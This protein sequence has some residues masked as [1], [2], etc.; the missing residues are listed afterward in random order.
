MFI[1]DMENLWFFLKLTEPKITI[2]QNTSTGR[3]KPRK[4]LKDK[5]VGVMK[6]RMNRDTRKYFHSE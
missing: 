6:N 2:T 4:E 5:T 1:D 3:K